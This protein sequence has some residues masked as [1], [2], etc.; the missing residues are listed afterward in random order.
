MHSLEWYKLRILIESNFDDDLKL[1][2][3]IICLWEYKIKQASLKRVWQYLK[4]LI[5]ILYLIFVILSTYIWNKN[6]NPQKYFFKNFHWI[7]KTIQSWEIPNYLSKRKWRNQ[8][9]VNTIFLLRIFF[10]CRFLVLWLFWFISSNC[11]QLLPMILI[12]PEFWE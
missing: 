2:D 11:K 1:E 7:F 10:K 8:F 3:L 4:K 9:Y 5:L 12:C 6:I